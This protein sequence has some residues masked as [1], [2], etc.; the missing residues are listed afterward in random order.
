MRTHEYV[1]NIP[2]KGH[3]SGTRQ[4]LHKLEKHQEKSHAHNDYNL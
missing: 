1:T 2:T 3:L 4:M